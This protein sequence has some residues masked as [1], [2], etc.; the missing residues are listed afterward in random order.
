[1][2]ILATN[3]F[4]VAAFVL[5][6]LVLSCSQLP[7][8][9]V[10]KYSAEDFFN[11][12]SLWGRGFSFDE[13]SIM[14]V[15]DQTGIYNT[16]K[17]PIDGS[18][19]KQMSHSTTD[20]IYGQT[21]MPGDKG[22][23]YQAD[24]GGNEI[25]HVFL[26]DEQGKIRDLTPG[27]NV[28]A[29]FLGFNKLMTKFYV[30]SNKRDPKFMDL[31]IYDVK[32]LKSQLIFKNEGNFMISSPSPDGKWLTLG[33]S[34]NNSDSDI[35]LVD[36]QKSNARPKLISKHTGE[37]KFVD[38]D[39]SAQ[40]DYFLYTTDE[41][42]EFQKLMKYDIKSGKK[43]LVFETNWDVVFAYHSFTGKY[44]VIGIN[45]DAQT[46]IKIINL[47]T[48][49]DVEL[50]KLPAGNIGNINFS[51]SDKKMMFSI[52][53]DKSPSNLFVIDLETQK[54]TQLTD[55]MNPKISKNDLVEGEVVRYPSFDNLPIPSVL[56]KPHV[57][58]SSQKVPALV[59]VH[60][61]PGG[62]SRKGYQELFQYLVNQG[63]AILAVNNRGSSGYGKTFFHMDDKK[64]GEVDLQDCIY[65]RK[66]LETLDW[67]DGKRIGIMGGSYGGYMVLAALAFAP[68]SFKLGVDIFGVS[69]WLRTLKSIPSWWEAFKQSLYSEMGDPNL[70]EEE[71]RLRKISPVFHAK[72]IVR[73]LFV[74]Q[75]KNDPRVLQSESDDIV[76]AVK[77]NGVPV[78][79]LIFDDEGHGFSKKVNRIKAANSYVKFLEQHL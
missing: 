65:G 43:S 70:K 58:S 54:Y 32:S 39:F 30:T 11:T 13:K 55:T 76:K 26:K 60:G 3:F 73:P 51:R 24:T 31:Y 36:L 6:L 25:F 12:T 23:I 37:A 2:V 33:K 17:Y 52:Y 75:G 42:S 48:G 56:Y 46:R 44:R 19:P 7:T 79:Y 71:A 62:Q 21:W 5:T 66:Y 40:S 1:M 35:Y 29:N 69:N 8:K 50:P 53:G 68:E 38:A 18:S 28:R 59:F 16:Y 72:N 14:V 47:H 67:V 34:N 15:S 74:V 63:Y 20:Q 49:K 27:T 41:N 78:E 45:E 9:S 64:H 10:P 61:G 22:F 57:A 77:Q 4:R